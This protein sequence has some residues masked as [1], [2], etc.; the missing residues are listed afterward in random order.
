MVRFIIWK[1]R[2]HKRR[3]LHLHSTMVRFIIRRL[4]CKRQSG[5]IIY[6]P[7]WLDLLYHIELQVSQILQ[8]LHSTMVRFIISIIQAL[9]DFMNLFTFHYG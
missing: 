8:N 9:P 7:L 4:H 3:H 1:C 5:K 2:S 6:I